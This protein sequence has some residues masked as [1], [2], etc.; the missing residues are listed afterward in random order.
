[1]TFGD[2]QFGYYETVAG[3]AGAGPGFHGRSGVHTHMTN[4][5]ITDVEVLEHRYPV[6]CRRFA[7]RAGSGG[8]GRF[9]GGDGC[10]RHLQFRRPL[11]LS[12]LTERR[13]FAPYGLEGG[14]QGAR[15]ANTLRVHANG[16]R[17]NLGAKNSV[18]VQAGVSFWH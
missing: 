5:R 2:A 10:A 18:H 16:A 6:I 14:E 17:I 15:G 1:M 3:G 7:L 9:R 13:V 4:T 12:L 11:Q 8:A